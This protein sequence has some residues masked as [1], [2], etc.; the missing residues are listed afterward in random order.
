MITIL[1]EAEHRNYNIN[2]KQLELINYA[3]ANS[4]EPILI[5]MEASPLLLWIM[6]NKIFEGIKNVSKLGIYINSTWKNMRNTLVKLALTGKIYIMSYDIVQTLDYNTK[7]QVKKYFNVDLPDPW[8]CPEVCCKEEREYHKKSEQMI[9]NAIG[10]LIQSK[11]PKYDN[12]FSKIHEH[13]YR[14]IIE[15][16]HTSYSVITDNCNLDK[17]YTGYMISRD[18]IGTEYINNFFSKFG[19][20]NSIVICHVVHAYYSH[21]PTNGKRYIHNFPE[22]TNRRFS[23]YSNELEP[24]AGNLRGDKKNIMVIDGKRKFHENSLETKLLK[25]SKGEDI[26]LDKTKSHLVES[27]YIM[28]YPYQFDYFLVA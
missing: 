22:N 26:Q 14:E 3:V 5:I 6:Q 13:I 28:L 19:D 7:K 1:A 16:L 10:K 27:S 24:F 4:E 20:Y 18:T 25:I 23:D 11:L 17:I 21:D 12:Q 9:N 2:K 8:V 15:N